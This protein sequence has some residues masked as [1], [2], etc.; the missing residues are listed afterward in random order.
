MPVSATKVD[1]WNRALDR[2][3]S[4]SPL[5]AE[6]EDD[7]ALAPSVCRRHYDDI[8]IEVL[9]SLPWAFARKQARLSLLDSQVTT[10]TVG[11]GDDT[12]EVNP[13]FIDPSQVTVTLDG[14]TLVSG[15]DYTPTP[16]TIS[17]PALIILATP[18]VGGETL[19]ITVTT[20][21]EGWAH[22]YALPND[23]VRAVA[24]LPDDQ[25]NDQTPIDSRVPFEVVSNDFGDGLLLCTDD[26]H[27]EGFDAFEYIAAITDVR[28]YP[29]TFVDCLAW[30][31][32]VELAYSLAKD[33]TMAARCQK[34][35]ELSLS[36]A[37]AAMR[38][39]DRL[40][41]PQTPSLAARNTASSN[42][43][44]RNLVWRR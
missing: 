29:R 26:E 39:N 21:R 19:I 34:H 31:L 41:E 2:I 16:A 33:D 36:K 37:R 15:T 44:T 12:F 18:A 5:A 35:Y 8:L 24:L 7:D 40:L 28:S 9:E 23:Y 4:T 22:V 6:N 43:P 10:P 1:I 20:S 38:S 25:R 32:A 3:G 14:A 30:R 13:G 42:V 27:G 11:A 17:T